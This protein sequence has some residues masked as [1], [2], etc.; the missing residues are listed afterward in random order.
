MARGFAPQGVDR[1]GRSHK[2]GF[3]LPKP[4]VIVVNS[5]VVRGAVGGRASVFALERMG[6]PVWSVP[7]VLVPWHLG[8]GKAS[9]ISA[10][11]ADFASLLDDLMRAPWLGEVGAVLT[12]YFGSAAQI[13]PVARLVEAVKARNSA[14]LFLCDPIIGDS[15]GLFQPEAVVLAIRDRLLP[16]ADIATPNRHELLWLT[17][18]SASNNE[19]LIGAARMLGPNGVIVTSAFA[20]KGEIANLCLGPGGVHLATHASRNQVPHGTGDLFAALYLGQ[21]LS[22]ISSSVALERASSAV[23]LLIDRAAELKA[24]EMPLA[25]GQEAFLAEPRG[26]VVVQIDRGRS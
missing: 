23:L 11:E 24:D 7:T 22:G 19:G 6:F 10:N 15:D 12:G 16:L 9:W 20:P 14:A 13:G 25:D 8:H 18:S 5:H 1:L 26:V 2:R 21:T 4:A 3:V 17:G